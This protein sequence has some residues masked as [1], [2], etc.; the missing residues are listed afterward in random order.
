MTGT[1]KTADGVERELGSPKNM[2][3]FR[4]IAQKEILADITTIV[5]GCLD[6]DAMCD[7][8]KV[9]SPDEFLNSEGK[10]E[11]P[12]CGTVVTEKDMVDEDTLLELLSTVEIDVDEYNPERPYMCPVC[13]AMHDTEQNARLCC[14]DTAIYSCPQ[15]KTLIPE[16]DLNDLNVPVDAQQ[17]LVVSKWLGKCLAAIG[18]QVMLTDDGAYL[19]ARM[20]SNPKPQEDVKI[21]AICVA[22]GI[23]EGQANYRE[24]KP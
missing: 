15:C 17:W 2:A 22:V 14:A 13:G 1:Y 4:K 11:C 12:F 8:D 18:E 20:H 7:T 21:A 23:L 6:A 19:W 9:I 24:V 3:V 5:Q 10:H 16:G